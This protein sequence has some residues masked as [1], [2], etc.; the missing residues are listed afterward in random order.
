MAKARTT[1]GGCEGNQNVDSQT[2]EHSHESSTHSGGEYEDRH[3]NEKKDDK[4]PDIVIEF[5]VHPGEKK[6]ASEQ[7]NDDQGHDDTSPIP[8]SEGEEGGIYYQSCAQI[9]LQ[10][11]K[12]VRPNLLAKHR[13]AP[14]TWSRNAIHLRR[15]PALSHTTAGLSCISS[16]NPRQQDTSTQINATKQKRIQKSALTDPSLGETAEAAGSNVTAAKLEFL[17][18]TSRF[19]W[20]RV[21]NS[22]TQH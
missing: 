6:I 5:S 20:R 11:P 8:A 12:E 7:R 14:I 13:H 4:R 16:I 3:G 1:F 22:I 21:V 17:A 18:T 10:I 9:S 2:N 19:K 15:N